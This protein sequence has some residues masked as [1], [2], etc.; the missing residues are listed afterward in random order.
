MKLIRKYLVFTFFG[1]WMAYIAIYFIFR[2]VAGK[3]PKLPEIIII[4]LGWSILLIVALG[5][6]LYA[7]IVPKIKYIESDDIK[8]PVF[9]DR[10][11]RTITLQNEDFSFEELRAKIDKKW[12]LTHVDHDPK[13][14]KFKTKNA[15]LNLG[16]GS[17]LKFDTTINTI[18]VSSF[19]FNGYMQRGGILKT[20]LND[21]I[22]ALIMN[23]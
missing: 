7:S 12:I 22:E 20:E 10:Q 17:Y 19:P 18:S 21:Q 4:G 16:I 13:V 2:T 14:I 9:G 8:A 3:D 5:G 1:Y 15:F 11:E 23:H 6:I